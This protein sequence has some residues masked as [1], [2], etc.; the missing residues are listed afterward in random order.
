MSADETGKC[1]RLPE[2]CLDLRD[3]RDELQDCLAAKANKSEVKAL[4]RKIDKAQR[5]FMVFAFT[6]GSQV[7]VIILKWALDK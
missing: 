5:W 4:E 7:V 6:L 2:G 1:Q 3:M